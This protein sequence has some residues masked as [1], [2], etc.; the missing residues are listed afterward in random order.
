MVV[1]IHD[2]EPSSIIAY[3]LASRTHQQLVNTASKAMILVSGG[4]AALPGSCGWVS[5]MGAYCIHVLL[6]CVLVFPCVFMR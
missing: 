2:A 6:C 3:F 1:P 5:S 4:Q